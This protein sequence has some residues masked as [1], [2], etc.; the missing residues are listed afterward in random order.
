MDKEFIVKDIIDGKTSL[1]IELGSTRIKAILI[2]CENNPIAS[3]GYDWENSLKNGIWTYDLEQVLEGVSSCYMDLKKDIYDKYRV[4]LKDLKAIGISAMMHG[5]LAFD[6]NDSLLVPFRTWRN[7]ITGEASKKLTDIFNYTIPQRWSVAHLYQSILNNEEHVK[8]ICKINTLAGYVHYLLTGSF[9]LGIGDASG[10]F[11][12]DSSI[13]DYNPNMISKFRE[14]SK[15][16]NWDIKDIL[17]KPLVAGEVAGYLSEKG[18]RLLDKDG[19]LNSK[20]PLCPAEGDA[21]TGMVATNSVKART[22]NV[23]AGT[24]VFAMIVLEKELSKLYEKLDLVTTPSGL[25]VAM[26][27]S[28]NCSGEIDKWMKLFTEVMNLTGGKLTKPQLYDA[29]LF[30]ALKADDSCDG[31]LSYGY[32]SGE[33]IT[34]F[35]EG[36]PLI[37]RKPNSELSVGNLIRSQLFTSLCAL[38]TGLN[39][40]FEKE[41][42][43]V[44]EI[45][46]HGGLFKT[47]EVGQ[48]IMSA[49]TNTPISV[50][51]SA[52]EGGAWGIAILASFVNCKENLEDYLENRV[53]KNS[54]KSTIMA[55]QK[56][57][58]GFNVFFKRYHDG[59]DIERKAIEI[60]R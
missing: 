12:I 23:S 8:D 9:N 15:N 40:L 13:K 59:L 17:P 16:Y 27:H 54:T 57:I 50:L 56:D 2:D 5:Y 33:H 32:L 44:D 19:D 3:G 51:T 43:K 26:A 55:D 10:M 20:I 35:E 38:R 25:P 53:F 31:I 14:L 42:V 7:N 60:L 34:G 28:N 21:G 46:G 47:A 29:I 30:E 36:R 41:N 39:I 18:A 52:G 4:V 49:A 22:G 11:P 58:E 1:G 45:N 48:K 37:V 24:S 6:K